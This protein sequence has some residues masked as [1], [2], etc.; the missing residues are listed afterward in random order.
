METIVRQVKLA[1]AGLD[2]GALG[3]CLVAYEPVW[4]IGERGV[5]ARPEHVRAAHAAIR[6]VLQ[7]R[8]TYPVTILYGGSVN[9][10][11][12]AALAVEREVD[13]LFIGRAAWTARGLAS[14]VK[15]VVAARRALNAA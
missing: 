12:A 15:E 5:P 9:V 10:E 2:A 8:T 11:N 1:F 14:I 3:R 13:G 7:E 4:A 6:H